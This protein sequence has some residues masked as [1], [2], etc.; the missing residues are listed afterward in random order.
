M[1]LDKE[2]TGAVDIKLKNAA[3]KALFDQQLSKNEKKSRISLN[4]SDLPKG[5]YQLEISNGIDTSTQTVT[6]TTKLSSSPSRLV[7][8]N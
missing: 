2:T 8:I 6:P 4:M 3:G 7:A 5:A 1:A